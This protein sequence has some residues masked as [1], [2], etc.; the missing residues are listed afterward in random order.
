MCGECVCGVCGEY[1]C[2]F[3][4]CVCV[5]LVSVCVCVCVFG[6]YVLCVY[7]CVCLVSVCVW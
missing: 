3:G 2:V 5:C 1:V 7:V 6:E 4:E